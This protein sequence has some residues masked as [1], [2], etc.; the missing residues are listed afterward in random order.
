LCAASPSA[1]PV[2]K[3]PEDAQAARRAEFAG[4]PI[5]KAIAAAYLYFPVWMKAAPQICDSG[6]YATESGRVWNVRSGTG[7]FILPADIKVQGRVRFTSGKA[8]D[9]YNCQSLYFSTK[10]AKKSVKN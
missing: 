1:M 6:L 5:F 2:T 4:G 9:T 8:S 10:P 7:E 3:E